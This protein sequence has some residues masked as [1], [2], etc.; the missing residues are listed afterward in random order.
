M[1]KIKRSELTMKMCTYSHPQLL[2]NGDESEEQR[3]ISKELPLFL[4]IFHLRYA[5]MDPFNNIDAVWCCKKDDAYI[6]KMA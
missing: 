3:G 6:E 4:R 5:D 1:K 2:L